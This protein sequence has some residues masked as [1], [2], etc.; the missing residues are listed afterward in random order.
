[1][2]GIRQLGVIALVAL[3]VCIV[4][5]AIWAG[6]QEFLHA[7][8]EFLLYTDATRTL[9][10]R[11]PN[12]KRECAILLLGLLQLCDEA[13]DFAAIVLYA[14]L[15][16]TTFAVAAAL[17]LV[18][19]FIFQAAAAATNAEYIGMRNHR[20]L[21]AFIGC[22]G[23]APFAAAVIAAQENNPEKA[24]VHGRLMIVQVAVEAVPEMYMV[25]LH[26]MLYGYSSALS[27]S[28]GFSLLDLIVCTLIYALDGD[29]DENCRLRSL[30][31][32]RESRWVQFAMVS[33]VIA[34]A[35]LRVLGACTLFFFLFIREKSRPYACFIAAVSGVFTLLGVCLASRTH[36][37]ARKDFAFCAGLCI[38]LF[39]MTFVIFASLP[40]VLILAPTPVLAAVPEF[41]GIL[42]GDDNGS[43]QDMWRRWLAVVDVVAGIAC[44]A[45][46]YLAAATLAS[47]DQESSGNQTQIVDE[48][49]DISSDG[50]DRDVAQAVFAVT[51]FF[52]LYKFFMLNLCLNPAWLAT[53]DEDRTSEDDVLPVIFVTHRPFDFTMFTLAVAVPFFGFLDVAV[54]SCFPGISLYSLYAHFYDD[55]RKLLTNQSDVQKR[56]ADPEASIEGNGEP[57]VSPRARITQGAISLVYRFVSRV[58]SNPTLL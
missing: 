26:T 14:T 28:A 5:V 42:T 18:V 35:C 39:C 54:R 20:G 41:V 44:A 16:H 55:E 45:I 21:A 25:L 47:M 12:R 56:R 34:D 11:S 48:D 32:I 33:F 22:A 40:L 1:M 31:E 43:W 9:H 24:S 51:L 8:Q 50:G 38:P 27:L 4:P 36:R 30:P 17:M 19:A 46:T 10:T 2:F 3:S 58:F 23:L 53:H 37:D 13:S 49:W 7:L 6:A 15:G 57:L 29:T 52:A